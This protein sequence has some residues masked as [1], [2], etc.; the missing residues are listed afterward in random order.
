MLNL[1]GTSLR[2]ALLPAHTERSASEDDG[3]REMSFFNVLVSSALRVGSWRYD[4]FGSG[5]LLL[6][7]I[8]QAH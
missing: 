4:E 3:T 2:D 7:D 8:R 5:R 6:G 1:H